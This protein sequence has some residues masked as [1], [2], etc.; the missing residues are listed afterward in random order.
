MPLYYQVEVLREGA[1]V[2]VLD[3]NDSCN[4]SEPNERCGGCG[5]CLWDQ[6]EF[7]GL[8]T[9]QVDQRPTLVELLLND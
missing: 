6:A 7:Y 8:K 1:V 9:R 2:A 5:V 3:P 4:P